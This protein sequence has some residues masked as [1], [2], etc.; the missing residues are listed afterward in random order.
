MYSSN[1]NAKKWHFIAFIT[2]LVLLIGLVGLLSINSTNNI[3]ANA[4][5]VPLSSTPL[6]FDFD[7]TIFDYSSTSRSNNYPL[8]EVY[9]SIYPEGVYSFSN[10]SSGLTTYVPGNYEA[11]SFSDIYPI[12]KVTNS[13]TY[14]Y[15]FIRYFTTTNIPISYRPYIHIWVAFDNITTG[16]QVQYHL[17]DNNNVLVSNKVNNWVDTYPAHKFINFGRDL[18]TFNEPTATKFSLSINVPPN[19]SIYLLGGI[20]L[21]SS[22]P[23]KIGYTES[24]M[25]YLFKV[26]HELY[27]DSSFYYQYLT[28]QENLRLA[29]EEGATISGALE[30]ITTAPIN[31][32]AEF[33]TFELPFF[34]VNLGTILAIIVSLMLVAF[35][36]KI[37]ISKG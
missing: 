35:V 16:Y 12:L 7:K 30:S 23:G 24:D 4:D 5:Y 1:T 28:S 11:T 36:I 18:S 29:Q 10:L 14:N 34:N 2:S 17:F 26:Y 25:E 31:A 15:N 8:G 6:V 9:S 27:T 20:R 13:H 32:L 37:L 21:T 33:M 19:S 3:T 22:L